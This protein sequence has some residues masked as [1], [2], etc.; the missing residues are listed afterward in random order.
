MPITHELD[1]RLGNLLACSRCKGHVDVFSGGFKCVD[2]GFEGSIKEGIVYAARTPSASFFDSRH[3]TMQ[4]GNEDPNVVAFCYKEQAA[5]LMTNVKAGSILLDV[6]CGPKLA[7]T[8]PRDSIVIG[9]DPSIASLRANRDLDLSILGSAEEIPLKTA[10]IDVAV[11]F[12]SLHHMVGGRRSDNQSK[13]SAAFADLGRVMKCGGVLLV[14]DMSPWLPIW[15]TQL[16]FW[17]LA[18]RVLGGKLDMFFWHKKR[19]AKFGVDLLPRAHLESGQF[20]VPLSTTF[21]PIFA[22]PSFRI[23]RALYPFDAMVYKWSF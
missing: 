8:K 3:G 2:C 17:N 12:Y 22:L 10:S 6:G 5:V 11:C 13:V 16:L 18:K 4:Q 21:P 19:V 14:F 15:W 9:L 23:P 1:E 7:Y 20:S